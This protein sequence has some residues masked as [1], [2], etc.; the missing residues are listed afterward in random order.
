M[1]SYKERVATFIENMSEFVVF[2][3]TW[4]MQAQLD[5]KRS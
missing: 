3:F 2:F 4:H 5:S 1:V